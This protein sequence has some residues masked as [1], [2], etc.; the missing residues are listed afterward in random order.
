MEIMEFVTLIPEFALVT[1]VTSPPIAP[2]VPAKAV[3]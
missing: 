1:L 3:A 2:Y